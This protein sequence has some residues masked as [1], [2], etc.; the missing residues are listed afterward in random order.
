MRTI[1][2]VVMLAYPISC[3]NEKEAH[4]CY[5]KQRVKEEA[6]TDKLHERAS[7][8]TRG[9]FCT[10]TVPRLADAEQIAEQLEVTEQKIHVSNI[11]LR[12]C[13]TLTL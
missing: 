7:P 3:K 12:S 11:H 1:S 6:G 13:E 10:D 9:G 4:S 5:R 8:A 2:D